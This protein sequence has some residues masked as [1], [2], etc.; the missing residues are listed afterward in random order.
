MILSRQQLA[1]FLRFASRVAAKSATPQLRCCLFGVDA[2]VVTDLDVSVRA[3]LPGARDIGVLV[4]ADVLKRSVNTSDRPDIYITR[5]PSSPSRPF[6]ARVD[7]LLISGYDA[8]EFLAVSALFPSG[9]PVAH[10]RLQALE[11]VLVAASTDSSHKAMYGVFFQ[12]CK[13]IAVAT[14]GHVLHT[15]EI[16]NADEGDFLLPRKPLDLVENIRKTTKT[17]AVEIDFFEHQ[18]VLRVDRFDIA[19]KLEKERFPAW[20]EVVP[21]K[22]NHTLRLSKHALLEALDRIAAAT[23]DR[24]TPVRLLRVE[25]GVELHGESAES[26]EATSALAA[27]GWNEGE[28]IGVNL[29]YLYNAAKFVAAD[30]LMIGISDETKPILIRSGAYFA[31]V[32]PFRLA[33]KGGPHAQRR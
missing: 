18:A 31:C 1:N 13:N 8:A 11:P 4:P 3:I 15:I 2:A 33:Q 14:N 17:A 20:E 25:G 19:T 22:S 7:E 26:G 6:G 5:E 16:E 30:E 29:S 32:M 27:H 28:E 12:L 21:P 24:S 9:H 10:A 23:G